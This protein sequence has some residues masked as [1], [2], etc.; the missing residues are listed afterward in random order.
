MINILK[1]IDI[2]LLIILTNSE[3]ITTSRSVGST[4]SP[5]EYMLEVA[6]HPV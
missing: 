6:L 4:P 1:L 5:G 2:T 3:G